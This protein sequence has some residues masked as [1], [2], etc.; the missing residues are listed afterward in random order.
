MATPTPTRAP[1]ADEYNLKFLKTMLL[2]MVPTSLPLGLA[3]GPF[4][5]AFIGA[6]A[7]AIILAILTLTPGARHDPYSKASESHAI[8]NL[9]G[10]SPMNRATRVVM[11]GFHLYGAI[12]YSIRSRGEGIVE[13]NE[14]GVETLFVSSM[15]DEVTR[16]VLILAIC[17]V[18]G[19]WLS[20]GYNG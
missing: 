5:N 6:S 15:Y 1:R 16:G 18:S 7:L 4:H 9:I 12:L 3:V 13:S 17:L 14:Y 19:I 20:S 10:T 11:G 2:I 8:K